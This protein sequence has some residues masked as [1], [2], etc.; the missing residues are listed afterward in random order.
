MFNVV[1]ERQLN[2]AITQ[3]F[4]VLSDHA[5]YKRFKVIETSRLLNPGKDHQNGVGA[6]RAVSLGKVLLHEEIVKFAHPQNNEE[7]TTA[8]LGYKI[9][10]SKPLKFDHELGEITL[11]A[12]SNNQTHV[13]W[14]SKG[15]IAFPILGP[16]F[17]DKQAQKNGV[18]A[19]NSILNYIENMPD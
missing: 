18:R 10:Y 4:D 12:N 3:V 19:F 15:R 1:V 13:R 9:I 14:Q 8:C 16:L 5:N 7:Q 2:K 11:T 6:I 17:M